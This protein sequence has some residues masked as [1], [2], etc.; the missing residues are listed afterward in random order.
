MSRIVILLETENRVVV[1][2]GWGW[3]GGSGKRMS[4]ATKFQLYDELR[5]GDLVYS[6]VTI[7]NNNPV[8]YTLKLIL[9]ILI[10]PV[11]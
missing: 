1:A 3:G 7:V 6:L 5:P 8:L 11:K 10:T 4:K 2:R 9:I